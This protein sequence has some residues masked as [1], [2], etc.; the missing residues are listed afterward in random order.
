MEELKI[1]KERVLAAAGTC[2]TARKALEELF[3]EAFEKHEPST[4]FTERGGLEELAKL[5][6]NG[7]NLPF[8]NVWFKIPGEGRQAK[9]RS[10]S[11]LI[12]ETWCK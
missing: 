12:Y 4:A 3:P 8:G 2:P 9:A 5:I 11:D 7:E 10:I 1:T 6:N